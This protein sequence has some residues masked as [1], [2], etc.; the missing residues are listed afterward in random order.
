M[1]ELYFNGKLC[2]E[3]KN[4]KFYQIMPNNTLSVV[5][6]VN[7]LDSVIFVQYSN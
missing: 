5:E 1:Q 3:D 2:D 6:K 4:L 7:N